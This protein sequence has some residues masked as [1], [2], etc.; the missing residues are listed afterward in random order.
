M[1]F[2]HH[3][4]I[5]FG[6]GQHLKALF[7]TAH[8]VQRADNQLLRFKRVVAVVLCFGIAIVI[9]QRKAQVEAAQHFDQPLML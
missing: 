6:I 9:K 8:K 2:I 4:Q 5:P 7:V 3:Q 1:R